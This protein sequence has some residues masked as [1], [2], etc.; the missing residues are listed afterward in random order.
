MF[1][2]SVRWETLLTLSPAMVMGHGLTQTPIVKGRV[3][4]VSQVPLLM[5]LPCFAA[6]TAVAVVT[7]KGEG[8]K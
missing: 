4:N 3:W 7:L 1:C 5:A 6:Y 2:K 8:S